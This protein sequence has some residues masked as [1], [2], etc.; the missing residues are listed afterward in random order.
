M[1]GLPLLESRALSKRFVVDPKKAIISDCIEIAQCFLGVNKQEGHA[2][3]KSGEVDALH[4]VSFSLYR[5]EC[6][7]VIGGNGAGKSTLLKLL[8]GILLPDSGDVIVR[9]KVGSMIELGAGFHPLLT[10]RENIYINA[11]I[12]GLSKHEIDSRL[13]KIIAF[14]E[15]GDAIDFPVQS[16]SSG[17]YVRLG[18][19]V[20]AHVQ[21]DILILDE[22]LAVGDLAFSGKCL[23]Y[24]SEACKNTAVVFVSHD[25]RSISRVSDK[26]LLLHKGKAEYYE[27]VG[28]GIN[29]LRERM[30]FRDRGFDQHYSEF[31][32]SISLSIPEK[33]NSSSSMVAKINLVLLK[34]QNYKVN[35]QAFR[36]DGVHCFSCFSKP[37]YGDGEITIELM[38]DP[39]KLLAGNYYFNVVVLDQNGV[40][41]LGFQEGAAKFVVFGES[42]TQGVYLADHRWSFP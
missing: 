10:G 19:A 20:A 16:Y 36:V 5:G 21:P 1:S 30:V 12:L 17:M 15:L 7:G 25:M 33:F 27:D 28:R 9:G 11:S 26:V 37:F 34:A 24:I 14:S 22:V 4:N 2:D 23:R 32:D 42:S 41:R 35:V 3:L 13:D 40:G 39:L 29:I 31:V 18:F 6:L 8:S 38:I